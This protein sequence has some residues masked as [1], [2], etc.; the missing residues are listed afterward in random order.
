MPCAHGQY[1][2]SMPLAFYPDYAK[3]S[4]G[5][6]ESIWTYSFGYQI[7]ISANGRISN[8]ILPEFAKIVE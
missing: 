7:K 4:I 6:D 2:Y 3:H 5:G 1:E 8:V